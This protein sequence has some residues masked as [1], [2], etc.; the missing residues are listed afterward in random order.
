MKL[1]YYLRGLGIGIVVT[2]VVMGV[3]LNKTEKIDEIP[4][5]DPVLTQLEGSTEETIQSEVESTVQ[6]TSTAESSEDISEQEVT[7][8]EVTTQE[9]SEQDS[10]ETES[11]ALSSNTE[12]AEEGKLIEIV[13][14]N[15]D[16]SNRVSRKLAESSLVESAATYD[17]FLCQNGYDKKLVAGTHMIPIG[18]TDDEI[19]RILCSRN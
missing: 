9:V 4:Q 8:Q 14:N 3:A 18:A 13:I 15:G 1:K 11:I 16:G 19:A 10:S 17:Q 2:A 6:E 7:T 12:I 5:K